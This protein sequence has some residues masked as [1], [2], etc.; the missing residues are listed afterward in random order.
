MPSVLFVCTAN[1][2][3]SP[4]AAA[5]FRRLLEQSGQ[6]ADWQVAS[7]GTWTKPGIPLDPHTEAIARRLGLD[8][9]GHRT[10][11]VSA[12]LLEQFDLILVMEPGH[13]EALSLEFPVSAP[14]LVLLPQLVDGLP[15]GIPDPNTPQAD[16]D[17]VSQELLEILKRGFPKIVQAARAFHQARLGRSD[18]SARSA[19]AS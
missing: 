8:L 3:R 1:Q 11:L 4:L 13:R 6:S 2:Y 7:A 12:E 15:S 9:S 14:R 19:G 18:P 10:C 17:E 5:I 16:L